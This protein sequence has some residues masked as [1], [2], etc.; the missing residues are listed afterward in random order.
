M[1]YFTSFDD[2]RG[3][4]S[5]PRVGEIPRGVN[6]KMWIMTG[7]AAIRSRQ[8]QRASQDASGH[9]SSVG[10]QK[11]RNDGKRET[12]GWTDAG[13]YTDNDKAASRRARK[14]GSR[15]DYERML[16]DIRSDPNEV[17]ILFEMARGQRDLSVYVAM[18]D[19][20]LE[21]GPYFWLVGDNLYDLRDK[22]DKQQLNAMASK[23]EGG[24][25]DIA[26]AVSAGLESQA[27]AG[28]PHG[29]IPFGYI[30]IK[31][32]HTGKFHEQV[33]D[34]EDRGGWN[35]AET[36]RWMFREYLS[37]RS[38]LSMCDD[39]NARGV[40]A[41]RLYGAT[42][43]GDTKKMEQ[44]AHTQWEESR[45]NN[46]LKNP[47]YIG[48]RVHKGVMTK[49][50]CW[51]AIV[52]EDDFF[53]AQRRM[54]RNAYS[55][56]RPSAAQTLLT[57]LARCS[58]GSEMIHQSFEKSATPGRAPV[59]RCRRGDAT[60]PRDA[61]DDFVRLAVIHFLTT[62]GLAERLKLDTRAD[63]VARAKAR[64]QE[65]RAKLQWWKDRAKDDDRPDVTEADYD[66]KAL[67]YLPLIRT[68]EAEVAKSLPTGITSMLA[69]DAA[70]RWEVLTL[71]RQ[72]EVLREVV[73]ITVFPA[74][75]GRRN[76]PLEDRM[77][78]DFE[79]LFR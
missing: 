32:I 59:Y 57:C 54:Q 58:C 44:W 52:S 29:P 71:V 48:V 61:A 53:A 10:T 46:I 56:E 16:D 27:Q 4:A 47:A 68:A 39:L 42:R 18:R 55:G 19:L 23:A 38:T 14:P 13:S 12:A 50:G 34:D 69:P 45:V 22:N 66:E 28:R 9:E 77:K 62:P 11:R 43:R 15:P 64:A 78:F 51:P 79:K 30:R 3:T 20:C 73:D 21:N 41:S 35:A 49:E 60:V 75:R 8:Y 36:V 76:A 6:G 37:G 25:D 65:Y 7:G 2:L 24:S 5:S 40:T 33:I 17:L 72:R 74:G 26:E 63:D 70:E 31:D 1:T 67:K